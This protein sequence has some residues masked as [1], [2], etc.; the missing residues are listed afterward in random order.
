MPEKIVRLENIG[1]ISFRS[2]KRFKRLSIRMAP[3]KGIWINLPP[4]VS[5][6]EAIDFAISNK[7]WIKKN[8]YKN[9][10]KESRKTIFNQET[11]FQTKYHQLKIN[12]GNV[13]SCISRL[14]NGILQITYP[15]Q[16]S[17]ENEKFQEFVRNSIIETL[18]REAKYYLPK[19]I[20]YLAKL[21]NF[22]YTSVQ[23]KNTKSRWGSCT[24]E[25]KINLSL[26]LMRLPED[27]S[28]M[29]IL[30]ELCHTK[31]KN[32]SQEFWDLLAQHC[33][34][35]KFKRNQIKKFSINII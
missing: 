35:L 29:V 33:T 15:K 32:H 16:I 28:D 18:R 13:K 4:G 12:S 2:N 22:K 11:L 23:I 1:D 26:H 21:H 30:H 19:R 17:V 27:L 20:E 10:L 14:S 24:H 7:E 31:V 6:Q 3:N 9:D 34:N 25:N 8:K 5:Y